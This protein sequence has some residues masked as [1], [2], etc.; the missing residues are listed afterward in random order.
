M[1]KS[2][3]GNGNIFDLVLSLFLPLLSSFHKCISSCSV[4]TFVTCKNA[5]TF[6]T[7]SALPV[8]PIVVKD[9]YVVL[10]LQEN[11]HFD[12]SLLI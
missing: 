4:F 1:T 11:E 2:W 12:L 6:A 5:I 3:L 9:A 10:F 8:R 7:S